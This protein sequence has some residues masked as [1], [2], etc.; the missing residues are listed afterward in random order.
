MKAGALLSIRISFK[1]FSESHNYAAMRFEVPVP[2]WRSGGTGR[3]AT[4]A[5]SFRLQKETEE[6][7]LEPSKHVSLSVV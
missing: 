7:A 2:D 1:A 3:K 4:S 5:V 6:M